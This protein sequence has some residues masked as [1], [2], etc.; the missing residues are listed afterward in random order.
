MYIK[1]FGSLLIALA[2]GVASFSFCRFQ[3]KR[4]VVIDGYISLLFY[5]KGQIDCYSRPLSDILLGADISLI[6][7]CGYRGG[8]PKSLSEMLPHAKIYLEDESMRLL[9]QFSEEFGSTYK[10]E[11]L[12]RCDYYIEALLERRRLLCDEIP[13]KSKVGSAVWM[14]ASFAL[15]I[16]LW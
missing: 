3:R 11:Q 8:V 13:S 14:C 6:E 5:I 15:M 7:S 10:Q 1:L 12:R 4:L 9:M 2:G 16:I